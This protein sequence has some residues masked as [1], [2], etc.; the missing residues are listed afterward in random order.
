MPGLL[1]DGGAMRWLV[2]SV[3]SGGRAAEVT[4]LPHQVV[5]CNRDS[6]MEA[7]EL[8]WGQLAVRCYEPREF[9]FYSKPL[10]SSIQGEGRFAL[11]E[12]HS[13]WIEYEDVDGIDPSCPTL[14]LLRAL[15]REC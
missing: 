13:C 7:G 9:R 4:R 6:G 2:R 15:L 11:L 10:G 8:G 12:D 14:V 5:W 3:Q 1:L